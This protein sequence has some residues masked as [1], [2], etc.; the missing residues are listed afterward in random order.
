MGPEANA[1]HSAVKISVWL[2]WTVHSYL[3][4]SSTEHFSP[5]LSEQ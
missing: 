5:S 4:P 3:C 1:L 2:F